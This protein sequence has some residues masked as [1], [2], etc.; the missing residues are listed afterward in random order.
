[1]KLDVYYYILT[2]DKLKKVFEIFKHEIN[3]LLKPPNTLPS[4]FIT[5]YKQLKTRLEYLLDE[6]STETRNEYEHPSLEHSQIGSLLGFGNSTSDNRGNLTIHVG[7]EEF[8]HVRKEL[9]DRLY[10]L[11]IEFIDLFIKHFT[12][13]PLTVDLATIKNNVD[14]HIDDLINEYSQYRQNDDIESAQN[15]ANR[16]L[17][18]ELHLTMEGLP[19]NKDTKVKIYT[20]LFRGE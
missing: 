7:K 17:A 15:L 1:M 20:I 3:N 13:K 10:S 9:V 11:W 19:L 5:E 12:D 16:L 2:W 14:E 4:E 18:L 6:H 8:A